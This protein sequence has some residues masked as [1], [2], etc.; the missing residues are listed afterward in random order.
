MKKLFVFALAAATMVGCSKSENGEGAKVP[1]QTDQLRVLT[2]VSTQTR[3]AIDGTSFPKGSY[4][5]VQVTKTNDT[6]LMTG[7]SGNN[8]YL[9]YSDG[10]NVRFGNEAGVNT[11]S[12]IDEDNKTHLFLLTGADVGRARGYYPYTAALEGVGADDNTGAKIPVQIQKTGEITVGDENDP[13]TGSDNNAGTFDDKLAYTSENEIDYM[14]DDTPQGDS[15]FNYEV[16]ASS[17]TTAKLRLAHAL[18]RVSF[19]MYT[20]F[21]APKA[22]VNDNDSY[23]ELVGYTIK[24]RTGSTE[25]C[26]NFDADTKMNIATGKLEGVLSG[27]EISRTIE[28]YKMQ[29]SLADTDDEN[30][31]AADASYRVSNLV[32]PL[33]QITP[34]DDNVLISKNIEVVFQIVKVS[35]TGDKSEPIGYAL[36]FAITAESGSWDRGKNYT[37]TVKFTGTA[38]SIETVTV[39]DWVEVIGGDMEIE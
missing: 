27:G 26:A 38:L 12:S 17:T 20:A 3:T 25:F 15:K 31:N 10:K 19:R 23:Y 32:F 5:G 11:W 28:G 30:K 33:N 18:S 29:R 6:E 39:T 7:A 35:G 13:S 14:Y 37:Y 34:D 4:I 24:N 16:S 9:Y 21:N 1:G 22:F 8:T 2:S 36:P